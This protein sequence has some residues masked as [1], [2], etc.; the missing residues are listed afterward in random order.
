V[1]FRF[2]S[3]RPLRDGSIELAPP[4]GEPVKTPM[5]ASGP[6]EVAGSFTAAQPGRL[7]FAI[8]DRDGLASQDRWE[9]PFTVTQDMAPEVRITEPA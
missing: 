2:L 5:A 8:T 3:N 9:A 4:E 1:R 7:R 6:N